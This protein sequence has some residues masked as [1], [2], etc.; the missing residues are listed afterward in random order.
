[1]SLEGRVTEHYA[2]DDLLA[3]IEVGMEAL[4][5]T[6]ETVTV[7]DLAPVDEFHIGGRIATTELCE[8]LEVTEDADVLDIGCGIGG[9]ARFVASTFGCTVTGIDLNPNYVAVADTLTEWTGLSD[10]VHF[11]AGSAL[12]MPFEDET[13]DRALQLHVGM[14]IADKEGLFA[15]V[16][17]VLEPGGRFGLYDIMRISAGEISY[18]VPWASESSHSFVAEVAVHRDALEAAGFVVTEERNRAEFAVEL[19]TAMK[20]RTAGA[21]GPPP[22]GLHVI[23]GAEAPTKIANMVEAVTSGI[24]APVELICE[25]RAR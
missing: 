15:E 8:R 23:M 21:G 12:D 1:M 13:F 18:P 14:N 5:R 3:A 11:E 25:K 6:T 7:E 4:G 22:L 17:R 10:R 16:S 24:L 9:A 2:G 19:F 20:A